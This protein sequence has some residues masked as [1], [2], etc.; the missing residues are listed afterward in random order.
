[1]FGSPA[2]DMS[3]VE[4]RGNIVV[5]DDPT[6][7]TGDRIVQKHG[8]ADGSAYDAPGTQRLTLRLSPTKITGR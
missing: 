6:A 4:V 8:Y 5:T 3:Y 2:D 1:M 7:N